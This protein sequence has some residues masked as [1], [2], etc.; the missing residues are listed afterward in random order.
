MNA[1]SI[2][3]RACLRQKRLLLL[4]ALSRE[5]DRQWDQLT[6]VGREFGSPDFDR[7]MALE[8][9]AWAKNEGPSKNGS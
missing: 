3:R 6:P 2:K 7:L 9:K 4:R 5:E 1:R 8:E